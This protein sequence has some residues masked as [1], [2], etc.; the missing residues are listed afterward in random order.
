MKA[1]IASAPSWV[2]TAQSSAPSTRPDPAVTPER[3]ASLRSV[4]GMSRP[5]GSPRG[6]GIASSMAPNIRVGQFGRTTSLPG[7]LAT[8][9]K[10]VVRVLLLKR[11]SN[12]H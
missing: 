6:E 8:P 4:Q 7:S 5:K 2:I 10:A 11:L 9:L 1:R 12:G 3:V